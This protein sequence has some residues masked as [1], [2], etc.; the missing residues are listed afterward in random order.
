MSEHASLVEL[1]AAID[2][3]I[4]AS[5]RRYKVLAPARVFAG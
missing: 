5:K 1:D 4:S 3:F 2:R